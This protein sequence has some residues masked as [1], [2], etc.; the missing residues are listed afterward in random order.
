MNQTLQI[1]LLVA[2]L[3]G[4][5]L[6]FF[7][8]Q[9]FWLF[10]GGAGFV[11]GIA[12]TRELMPG[13]ENWL[14]L[15]VGLL[16]G[17]IG[18]LLSIFIQRLA[19]GIA[20]FLAGGYILFSLSHQL[21]NQAFAW[22]AFLIGGILGGFLVVILFDWALIV[23]SSMTGALLISQAIE[24]DPG[25]AVLVLVFGFIAGL[26]VQAGNFPRKKMIRESS[27]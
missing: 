8:R 20:G 14:V 11:V 24:M 15:A 10:V 4:L 22:I 26:A 13:Q 9:L 12:I 7:G 18:A 27:P 5:A 3:V 2:L 16:A 6:L 21:G 19:V 25:I 23:L 17:I 1:E